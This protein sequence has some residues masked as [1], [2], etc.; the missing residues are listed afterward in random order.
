MA[1]TPVMS[2]LSVLA[3]AVLGA[4]GQY[5]FKAGAARADGSLLSLLATPWIP[6]AMLCY[7]AVMGLFTHAFRQGGT[8]GVLY[9]VYASTFIWAAVLGRVFYQQPIR[10]VH[11]LGMALLVAGM[12]CMGWGGARP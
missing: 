7:L 4:A 3:A 8:V 2:I 6:A 5:L 12:C 10:P 1:G 11:V 9:P